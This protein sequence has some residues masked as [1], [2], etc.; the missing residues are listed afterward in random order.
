MATNDSNDGGKKFASYLNASP[1]PLNEMIGHVLDTA[2]TIKLG[3][4]N[5]SMELT[6]AQAFEIAT[7]FVKLEFQL[8]SEAS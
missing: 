5:N 1:Y 6:D 3:A 4:E 7:E 8:G 2:K